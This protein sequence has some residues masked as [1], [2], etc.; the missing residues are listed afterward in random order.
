MRQISVQRTSDGRLTNVRRTFLSDGRPLDVCRKSDGSSSVGRPLDVRWSGVGR[1]SHVRRTSVTAYGR[2]WA[3]AVQPRPEPY[4]QSHVRE[5]SRRCRGLPPP[6][7]VRQYTY[8]RKN[9]RSRKFLKKNRKFFKVFAK[10][11]KKNRF[12]SSFGRSGSSGKS[13]ATRRQNFSLL[14]RLATTKTSKKRFR[15]K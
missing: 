8:Y 1:P 9:K 14:R 10:I 2:L 15:K 6:S 13:R 12:R 11:R 5:R 3:V 7:N 4:R